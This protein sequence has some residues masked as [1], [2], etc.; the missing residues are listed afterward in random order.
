[1]VTLA[2]IPEPIDIEWGLRYDAVLK[3]D[4]GRP[5]LLHSHSPPVGG[6]KETHRFKLLRTNTGPRP[7][8]RT[9]LETKNEYAG[10][11]YHIDVDIADEPE[12]TEGVIVETAVTVSVSARRASP[13]EAVGTIVIEASRT[14]KLEIP[15]DI[16]VPAGK[17]NLLVEGS[18]S[19]RMPRAH[20]DMVLKLTL[21]ADNVYVPAQWNVVAECFPPELAG[22]LHAVFH[23]GVW[24][25]DEPFELSIGAPVE[26]RLDLRDAESWRDMSMGMVTL[27]LEPRHGVELSGEHRIAVEPRRPVLLPRDITAVPHVVVKKDAFDVQVP[28]E[29]VVNADGGGGV[30]KKAREAAAPTVE[31][32]EGTAI[33][34]WNIE[35]MGEGRWRIKPAAVQGVSPGI[36]DDAQ[37]WVKIRVHWPED[38]VRSVNYDYEVLVDVPARW[39]MWGYLMLGL[40]A[41]A[42]GI[43]VYAFVQLRMP[44]VTGTL[45]YAIDG[46]DGVV[47]RL[48]LRPV[49]RKTTPVRSDKK[50][51]LHLNGDG[52]LVATVVATRVGGAV[53]LNSEDSTKDRRLLVDGLAVR[54]GKHRLRYMSGLPSETEKLVPAMDVPDLLGPEYNLASGRI[55]ATGRDDVTP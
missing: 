35:S 47:G 50:G 31:V 24:P 16:R 34:D 25:L 46:V 42:L 7:T 36:F 12:T 44:P 53:E 27:H 14:L 32:L 13:M 38:V 41:V 22:M 1:M 33:P 39:G 10:L 18:E 40:A 20:A 15:F 2:A 52:E 23:G 8:W 4:D 55:E 49:G 29:L 5:L 17:A 43:G 26:L 51:K 30:W 11:A 6:E 28:L 45:L 48:D 9:R 21:Q 3:T 54:T 19:L 37:Q